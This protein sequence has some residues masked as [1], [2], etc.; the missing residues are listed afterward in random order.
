MPKYFAQLDSQGIVQKVIVADSLEWCV[1][2]L[3][4]E[5]VETFIDDTNK[6]YAGKGAKYHSGLDNF[7]S[8]KP[9][10]SWSLDSKLKWQPP[11][12]IPKDGKVY[13]WNEEKLDWEVIG[14]TK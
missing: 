2:N 6:N 11:K 12:I 1:L 5:W 10:E 9:Y 14:D 7:S 3:G 8:E 13:D 4:G